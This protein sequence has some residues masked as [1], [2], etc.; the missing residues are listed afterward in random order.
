MRV[1]TFERM[2]NPIVAFGSQILCQSNHHCRFW[3]IRRGQ[4][5]V[6][7]TFRNKSL[8]QHKPRDVCHNQQ[9]ETAGTGIQL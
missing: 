2:R 9:M 6:S 1:A 5:S 4:T 3:K 8:I 7:V